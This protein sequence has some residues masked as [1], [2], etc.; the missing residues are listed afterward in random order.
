MGK[1]LPDDQ[2]EWSS[3]MRQA[4]ESE[5]QL[6]NMSPPSFK[7]SF[8]LLWCFEFFPLLWDFHLANPRRVAPPKIFK[9]T[10]LLEVMICNEMKTLLKF[11][12]ISTLKRKLVHTKVTNV[13]IISGDGVDGLRL[14]PFL[15]QKFDKLLETQPIRVHWFKSQTFYSTQHMSKF[16]ITLQLDKEV[17]FYQSK[18][19]H[20]KNLGMI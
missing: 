3:F 20:A 18:I 5:L 1:L 13:I 14:G 10:A 12:H 8:F 9:I 15:I 11:F 6:W 4:F 17:N 2:D 7:D 19:V 16:V